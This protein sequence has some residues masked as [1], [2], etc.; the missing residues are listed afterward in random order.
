[1]YRFRRAKLRCLLAK[2][3]TLLLEGMRTTMSAKVFR[4]ETC[5]FSTER[6]HFPAEQGT[7][8]GNVVLYG[9][10]GGEAYV[11]GKAG[12][13]F[14]VRNSGASAVVESVGDHGCEYMTNGVVIVL[15]KTGKNFA[16][17]MS[18][19]LA[20]CSMRQVIFPR[21]S[22]ITIMVELEPLD[23]GDREVARRLIGRH[24]E[25]T[26]SPA[27]RRFLP[28]RRSSSEVRQGVSD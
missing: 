5:R 14:A 11:S 25:L 18:G 3:V 12:E 1:M 8:V 2:G 16:A 13:R 20:Y 27:E 22:A 10:T 15:G 7:V 21:L 9:A 26:G 17:G 4:R 19:G 6:L 24:V 28:A 23:A